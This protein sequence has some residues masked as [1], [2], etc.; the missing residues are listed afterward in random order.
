MTRPTVGFLEACAEAVCTPIPS[1][2]SASAPTVTWFFIGFPLVERNEFVPFACG[3]ATTQDLVVK[4]FAT[5]AN[6]L[7]PL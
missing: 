2:R 4:R 6:L 3:Q 1:A 7:M 5:A